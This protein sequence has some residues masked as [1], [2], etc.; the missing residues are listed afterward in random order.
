MSLLTGFRLS[1][2]SAT[3]NSHDAPAATPDIAADRERPQGRVRMV[4]V[5][6]AKLVDRVEHHARAV[7]LGNAR[8]DQ[9]PDQDA[10]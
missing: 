2:A 10:N 1:G 7:R 6:P 8:L 4:S 9:V 5:A 3:E